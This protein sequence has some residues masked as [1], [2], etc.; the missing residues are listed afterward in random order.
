VTGDLPARGAPQRAGPWAAVAIAALALALYPDAV[1][2]GRAFYERDV[3]LVWHPQVEAFVRA[4]L[5]G[6]WPVWNPYLSFG[7]PMLANPHTQVLYPFTW[8]NLILRPTTFYTV[9]V[10]AH[11]AFAGC[12][13]FLLARRLG[14]SRTAGCVAAACW[15][16]SGP[17]LSLGNI[18]IQLAGASWAPWVLLAAEHALA[19]R[20]AVPTLLWGGAV[21]LQLFAGSPD[22]SLMTV[23]AAGARAAWWFRPRAGRWPDPRDVMVLAAAAAFA[24][25]LSAGLWLPALDLTRQTARWSLDST[26]AVWS[27][28]PLGLAEMVSPVPLT[29]LPLHAGARGMLYDG[30][31]PLI[32]SLYLG[33]PA[34]GLV[35]AAIAGAA[36][37]A[38]R[39]VLVGLLAALV[40][41]LGRN[42]PL[43]EIA[44]AL[45][46]PLRVLRYP[47]KAMALVAF[48][49]ALLAGMG[50]DTWSRADAIP[51]RRWLS[52]VLAP[53]LALAS[54]GA[55]AAVLLRWRPEAFGAAL[56]PPQALS[57]SAASILDQASLRVALTASLAAVV[58]VAAAIRLARPRAARALAGA[59]AAVAILDL[60]AA[61]IKVNPTVPV[62][63]YKLR[64]PI[65]DTVRQDD[66]SRL[67]VY[68]Y[69]FV[70]ASSTT[71]PAMDDPYLVARSL[72][73]LSFDAARTL[74][75]RLYVTPP[76]GGCWGLFGSYE[77]DL[78]GLYPAHLA[79]VTRWMAQAE[80]TPAWARWLRIGAVRHVSA[81]RRHGGFEDLSAVAVYPSPLARHILLLE[82]PGALPRTYAVGTARAA[83]GDRARQVLADP[84][85]DPAREVVLPDT[86][87]QGGPTFSGHSRI[88]GF[89]AD[90]VRIEAELNEPGI[91]VL[92]D[93]YDPGWAVTVDG[94]P[95]PLLR[96]NVA[97]RAVKVAAGKHVIEHVY[98]PW[99]VRYGLGASAAAAL[100]GVIVA[101]R[102]RV[103][104]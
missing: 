103:R 6:S 9:F 16:A 42:T 65:L 90:R 43:Y 60:A 68:R 48:A 56:L 69:P 91:V 28:H 40:F 54:A 21:A 11:T 104:R 27:V 101:F 26:R 58:V 87:L 62:E 99:T 96:A 97:F 86:T 74:A 41:A 81:L 17:F 59:V 73:G 3:H 66:L 70:P 83:D 10:V 71:D 75:L 61:G 98:R 45:A 72:P 88:V 24:V 30:G 93:S 12:G 33:I 49:W 8:L 25:V 76:V 29:D 34:L 77:P 79:E 5:S 32:R 57:A 36:W 53:V 38:R 20:A 19:S 63:F 46:P 18:W 100:F 82:V 55:A 85:F 84:G 80:A 52:T 64:P 14:L 67:Y 94:Q 22:M 2:R 95:A 44:V 89:T 92:V 37:P 102:N 47:S 1:F 7:H 35:A 39:A 23:A 13:L 50:F 51:R 78:I 4:V 31:A 15:M